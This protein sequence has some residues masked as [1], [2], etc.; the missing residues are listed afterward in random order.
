MLTL[1]YVVIFVILFLIISNVL[2]ENISVFGDYPK[3]LAF[4]VTVLC[5]IG[6]FEVFSGMEGIQ[7][8][9]VLL[10]YA[11][12]AIWIIIMFMLKTVFGFI[13]KCSLK[14]IER[15]YENVSKHRN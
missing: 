2:A 6:M 10:P 5:M 3:I 11:A 7:V 14:K 15:K 1:I 9:V 8:N 12:L 13:R 4:C